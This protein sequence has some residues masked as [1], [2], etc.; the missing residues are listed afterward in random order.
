MVEEL[1][2]MKASDIRTRGGI[3]LAFGAGLALALLGRLRRQF[4]F[5]R[6]I[7]LITGGSRGLGLLMARQL[8]RERARLVLL[9]RNVEKLR[10]AESELAAQGATV[11]GIRC[12]IR[13]REQVDHAIQRVRDELGQIDVL[14]NNAGVI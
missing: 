4:S 5:Q 2:S 13:K 1:H 8:A 14:I 10:K 7:V 3:A 9:A 12:D 6:R 11:L